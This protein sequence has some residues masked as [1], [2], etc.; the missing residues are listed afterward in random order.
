MLRRLL[1]LRHHCLP[2]PSLARFSEISKFKNNFLSPSN[3]AFLEQEHAQWLKDKNS[4]SKSFQ[5]YFSA[6]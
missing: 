6:I 3:L 5:A 1:K 4:V 2:L